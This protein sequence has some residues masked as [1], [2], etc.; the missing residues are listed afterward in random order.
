MPHAWAPPD[1]EKIAKLYDEVMLHSR[2]LE[3]LVA[4]ITDLTKPLGY[5]QIETLEQPAKTLP[6]WPG[7]DPKRIAFF[8][9]L[10]Y[11]HLE[12]YLRAFGLDGL[13]TATF[14]DPLA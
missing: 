4:V 11:Q 5:T 2:P 8:D 14:F 1:L 3:N 12:A 13:T 10:V 6:G 9:Q 7:L